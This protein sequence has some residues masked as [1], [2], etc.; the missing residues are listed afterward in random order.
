MTYF[1]DANLFF[2]LEAN[3]VAQSGA[4]K[5]SLAHLQF[6]FNTIIP[7]ELLTGLHMWILLFS[8]LRWVSKVV[9]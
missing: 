1:S 3:R 8:S 9:K 2:D 7:N 5:T 4:L 6:Y